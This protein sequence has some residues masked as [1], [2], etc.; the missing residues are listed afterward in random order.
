[1]G[2]KYLGVNHTRLLFLSFFI[3]FLNTQSLE[4]LFFFIGYSMSKQRF[5][6]MGLSRSQLAS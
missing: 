6:E 5:L 3:C 2:F 1:M 4:F